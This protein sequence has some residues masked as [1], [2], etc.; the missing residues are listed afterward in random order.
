MKES[1]DYGEIADHPI[2]AVCVLGDLLISDISL[3]EK[4]LAIQQL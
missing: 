4:K 2:P 3:R 1:K